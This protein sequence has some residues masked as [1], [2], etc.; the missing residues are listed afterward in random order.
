METVTSSN[1]LEVRSNHSLWKPECPSVT[2]PSRPVQGLGW[3]LLMKS[4]LSISKVARWLPARYKLGVVLTRN[5]HNLTNWIFNARI[6]GTPLWRIGNNFPVIPG[7]NTTKR[8]TSWLRILLLLSPGAR[9]LKT[10]PRSP[11]SFRILQQPRTHRGRNCCLSGLLFS[12]TP[13]L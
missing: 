3:L 2:W 9:V 5:C 13:F 1:L 11:V 12:F 8:S 10:L 6:H 7:Q 4:R